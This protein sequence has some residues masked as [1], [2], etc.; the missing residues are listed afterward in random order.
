[1]TLEFGLSNEVIERRRAETRMVSYQPLL[2][3]ALSL[4]VLVDNGRI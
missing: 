1:M 4:K 3:K 2:I